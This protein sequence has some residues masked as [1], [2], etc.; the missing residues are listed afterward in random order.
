[1]AVGTVQSIRGLADTA[2]IGS[3]SDVRRP[4]TRRDF[5]LRACECGG[6]IGRV[7]DLDNSVS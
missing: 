5:N 3:E 7:E 4:T 2:V 1:V 6:D